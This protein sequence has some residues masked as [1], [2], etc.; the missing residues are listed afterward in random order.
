LIL[1]DAVPD[2]PPRVMV[3]PANVAKLRTTFAV[4]VV[5]A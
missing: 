2:V 3:L 1:P 4:V 5:G